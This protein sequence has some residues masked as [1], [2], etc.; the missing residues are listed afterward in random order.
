MAPIRTTQADLAARR[1]PDLNNANAHATA[2]AYA[3]APAP[4]PG[5]CWTMGGIPIALPGTG[6]K[7]CST[8]AP[9]AVSPPSERSPTL[10]CARAHAHR[11]P[12][13][14]GSGS[15]SS[16]PTSASTVGTSVLG[17]SPPASELARAQA[18]LDAMQPRVRAR[19]S[20]FLP[21]RGSAKSP[22]RMTVPELQA[23]IKQRQAALLAPNATALSPECRRQLEATLPA[24]QE[25]LAD[26]VKLADLGSAMEHA[27]LDPRKRDEQA[28]SELGTLSLQAP[29]RASVEATAAAAADLA[30]GSPH[31]PVTMKFLSEQDAAAMQHQV[32]DAEQDEADFALLLPSGSTGSDDEGTPREHGLYAC[33]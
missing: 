28:L 27:S 24:L 13:R 14:A 33:A 10:A 32:R 22:R 6:G 20:V 31:R 9:Y 18:E 16:S 11:S 21:R 4:A 30:A 7:R 1:S 26:R 2:H 29:S 3:H 23:A 19:A 12:T 15:L 17:T 5:S 8:S 25:T